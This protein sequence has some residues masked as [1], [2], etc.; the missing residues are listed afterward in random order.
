MTVAEANLFRAQLMV[1]ELRRL[2]TSLFVVCPGSRSAPLTLALSQDKRVRVV[3]HND[4]RG[5]GYYAVGYARATRQPAAVVTTS[6]TAAVNLYPAIV[7]ASMDNLPLLAV[8]A[9]RPP[10]LHDCGANQTID[11]ASLFG[12]FVRCEVPLECPDEPVEQTGVLSAIDGMFNHAFRSLYPHGPAHINCQFREPL[13]PSPADIRSLSDTIEHSVPD[14][15]GWWRSGRTYGVS[16]AVSTLVDAASLDAVAEVVGQAQRGILIIGALQSE[17][18]Q[19]AALELS[20]RLAWPTLADIT[21]GLSG[22]SEAHCVNHYDLALASDRFGQQNAPET[23]LHVG[24]RISSKRLLEFID[25][26]RPSNYFF[27]AGDGVIIDPVHAVTSRT[28]FDTAQFCR[29]L[30]DRVKN[31]I[32]ESTWRQNWTSAA[33]HARTVIDESCTGS[34]ALTEPYLAFSLSRR[35]KNPSAFFVASS[36]PIRDMDMFAAFDHNVTI[37][38]NR[39]ASGIDGTIASACGFAAGLNRPVTLLLGDQAFLHDLNALALVQHS[40]TPIIIVI[41]NNNGGRIFELLPVSDHKQVLESLFVAPHNL[42]FGKIAETYGISHVEVRD[43]M[44]FERAYDRAAASGLSMIIEA[45]ID[46]VVSRAHRS[47]IIQLVE[48]SADRI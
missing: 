21:S 12:D 6:G 45:I 22:S 29:M 13:A 7:E 30:G 23:I 20:R 27:N 16:A 35:L 9:D 3:V 15:V 4:E 11:Q 34:G 1:E 47:Q 25:H 19:Q 39:G 42:T 38:A 40:P 5:A 31:P 44:A 18:E 43:R 33:S 41:V 17:Q 32:A 2:G 24:G 28:A 8:T 48:T 26:H 46:P 36:M 37:A 10:E 14:L